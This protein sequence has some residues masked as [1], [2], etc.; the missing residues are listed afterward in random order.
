MATFAERLMAARTARGLSK[1]RLAALIERNARSALTAW[2]SGGAIPDAPMLIRLAKVLE[3]TVDWLLGVD[4]EQGGPEILELRD[5]FL[6][7]R[8]ITLRGRALTPAERTRIWLVV[9]AI[10]ATSA[11]LFSG[12]VHI[13]ER[14]AAA[15]K[16]DVEEEKP[17][18]GDEV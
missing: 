3:V 12:L 10:G 9:W 17:P 4:T 7:P 14:Y 16:E 8:P 1:A 18:G 6:S 11:A 13:E 15:P 2:E 5:V